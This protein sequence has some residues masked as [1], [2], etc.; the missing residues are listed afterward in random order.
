MFSL[1]L[2][3]ERP[4]LK[5][6]R[7]PRIEMRVLRERKRRRGKKEDEEK[8]YPSKKLH[9]TELDR[10]RRNPP[11]LLQPANVACKH[12]THGETSQQSF[13]WFP[14]PFYGKSQ[15]AFLCLLL[16][17]F[18]LANSLCKIACPKSSCKN[19]EQRGLWRKRGES[20]NAIANRLLPSFSIPLKNC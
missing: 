5:L 11:L 1:R 8:K 12:L 14:P 19:S 4:R 9:R 13:C 18:Q 2:Y 15:A 3:L 17:G 10:L 7:L 20:E 16:G 6:T